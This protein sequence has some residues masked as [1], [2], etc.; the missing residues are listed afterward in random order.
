M[1]IIGICAVVGAGAARAESREEMQRLL[2]LDKKCEAA[3]AVR[4]RA[5]QQQKIE[6]C[7][8]APP[9]PRTER[10]SRA[11]C[12][13]YWN[14]YGWSSGGE[15]LGTYNRLFEEIPECLA[16]FEAWQSHQR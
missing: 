11:Q 7:V 4:I 10:M 9:E 1:A 8:N 12:E 2:D 3:R 16:A 5:V 14:D 15:R 13:R 6:E